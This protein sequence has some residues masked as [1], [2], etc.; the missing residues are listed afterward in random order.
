LEIEGKVSKRPADQVR[1][2]MS[3]GEVEINVDA[4]TVLNRSKPLPFLVEDDVDA[5]E[6]L[7]LK[8]RYLDLRRP[9][10]Q[11]ILELR[12]RTAQV[13]RKYLSDNGFMEI[14]TPVLT[15]ST[16]EGARDYLVPSRIN[17]GNFYALP[18]SPQIFKQLLMISGY[19][20]YFQIVKCF[21]D[22]DLRADRQPEFTQI[23]IETSFLNQEGLLGIM[24]N[25]FASVFKEIKGYDLKLPLEKMTYADAMRLYGSDRPDRRIP[26]TLCDLTDLFKGSGFNA[27]AGVVEKGGIVKGLNVG[28]R[29]LSR[30]DI[31]E[32]EEIAKNF[33][34]KG[35]AWVKISS[36]K[37][38]GPIAKF[39]SDDEK[40]SLVKHA[41]ASED[42]II[43][44]V[45]DN[46]G[47]VNDALG[48]IR[49]IL[50]KK[51]NII[52]ESKTDI[53][54][55]VDFPLLEWNGDEHR[56]MAVH[57]PFTAPHPDDVHLLDSEP[58]KARSLAYD[59]I[60]NGN[61]VGGGSIRIHDSNVQSKIF[62][63]LGITKDEANAKFGF[64]LEALQYGAPP[65]GG[66]ALGFDRLIMLLAGTDNIR[67]VIAFPKTTSASDL[68]AEAPNVV[69][70]DQLAELGIK[71]K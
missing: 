65:H 62:E 36:E 22:E 38:G 11:K 35:L 69:S 63:A 37:W 53:F 2:N 16:P 17:K 70:N 8:H 66:V 61:E 59:V 45:A 51:L 50:G 29:E 4:L 33:G 64:L 67:D 9:C 60:L 42:D 31:G 68:M 18:Q 54:W 71:L 10:L 12:H 57:H 3:T 30:K 26:W 48:N 19:D 23:D 34:A 27:F 58:A 56:H 39:L 49:V 52:D 25:L 47:I 15:K 40:A 7:R 21:R 55:V 44:M 5:S 6:E 32:L 14:E 43:L 20:R 24:D 13:V 1:D 28:A 46:Q 41:D